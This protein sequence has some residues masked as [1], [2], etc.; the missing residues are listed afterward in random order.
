MCHL[1][2]NSMM[3]VALYGEAKL[4]GRTTPN[5]RDSPIAMSE[6]PEKSKYSCSVYASAPLQDSTNVMLL[7]V[8]AAKN[9]EFA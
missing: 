3:L 8:S 2:Q 9:T 6:Y 5:M 7:P 1:R 4:I